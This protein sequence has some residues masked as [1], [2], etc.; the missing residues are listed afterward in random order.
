MIIKNGRIDHRPG[1]HDDSVIAWLLG[2]WFLSKA[3][4][5]NY[6][7]LNNSVLSAVN[8]L[9]VKEQGGH[10]AIQ[11][12]EEKLYIKNKISSLMKQL[13]SDLPAYKKKVIINL[14]HKLNSELGDEANHDLNIDNLLEDVG[15][16]KPDAIES[17]ELKPFSLSHSFS[18]RRIY[19][20]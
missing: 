9:I 19:A 2:Y 14:I 6:Y 4:N 20:A 10:S 13:E 5:K 12:R 17:R 11:D 18:N 8:A 16:V 3:K 1:E 15:K 7:G